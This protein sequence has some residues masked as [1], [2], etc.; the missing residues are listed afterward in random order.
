[1]AEHIGYLL[2]RRSVPPDGNP[3][4]PDRVQVF[5]G[6]RVTE[7]AAEDWIAHGLLITAPPPHIDVMNGQLVNLNTM[8]MCS[9][10]C[11]WKSD[12]RFRHRA[13]N[14]TTRRGRGYWC[15]S[16]LSTSSLYAADEETQETPIHGGRK[17]KAR[18]RQ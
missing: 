16:C 13:R 18:K 4:N 7:Q 11:Q 15:K 14:R 1:M 6:P 17:G 8:L 5:E 10:C 9:K 2:M 12:D 3:F